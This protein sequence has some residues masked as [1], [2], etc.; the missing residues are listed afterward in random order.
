MKFFI[1]DCKDKRDITV[2]SPSAQTLYGNDF[3]SFLKH[4]LLSVGGFQEKVNKDFKSSVYHQQTQNSR[5]VLYSCIPAVN[6]LMVI[7]SSQLMSDDDRR[8]LQY[9][10]DLDN[11]CLIFD[12]REITGIENC[13]NALLSNVLCTILTRSIILW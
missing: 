6:I 3:K 5:H 9:T 8:M 7:T 1:Y 11:P 4:S 10:V 13:L 12:N 2:Q